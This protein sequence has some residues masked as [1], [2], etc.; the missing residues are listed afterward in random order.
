MRERFHTA[1]NEPPQNF[2]TI[3]RVIDVSDPTVFN[4]LVDNA[5][6]E[7]R[8]LVEGSDE[9]RALMKNV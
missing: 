1:R 3:L 8:L 2:A 5:Q 7:N 9:A 4:V 6:I